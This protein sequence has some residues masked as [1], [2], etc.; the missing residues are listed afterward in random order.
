MSGCLSLAENRQQL[1]QERFKQI[2]STRGDRLFI[3]YLFILLS[4]AIVRNI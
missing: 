2:K 3:I 1:Y 4:M